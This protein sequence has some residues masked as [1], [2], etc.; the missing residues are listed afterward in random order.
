[1]MR[2]KILLL[3]TSLAIAC[4]VDWPGVDP[5]GH[6]L[7]VDVSQVQLSLRGP[8]G[9]PWA[10]GP[11]PVRAALE[12]LEDGE[13]VQTCSTEAPAVSFS[14][15]FAPQDCLVAWEAPTSLRVRIVEEDGKGRSV[16]ELVELSCDID[17]IMELEGRSLPTLDADDADIP[18]GVEEIAFSVE[19]L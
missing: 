3:S 8:A 6:T 7:R 13:V 14:P 9:K 19:R 15:I 12:V 2:P 4:L 16:R 10:D 17:C 1:M 11:P 18:T 5:V